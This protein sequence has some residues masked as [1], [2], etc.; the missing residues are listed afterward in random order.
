MSL[1][2]ALYGGFRGFAGADADDF[3]YRQDKDF[4]VADFAGTC[5]FDNGFDRAFDQIVGQH[6]LDFDFGQEIDGVFGTA[7]DFGVA[8]WRPKP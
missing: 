1:Q 4:A 3:F 2:P 7:I 6:Q 8:F 5:G